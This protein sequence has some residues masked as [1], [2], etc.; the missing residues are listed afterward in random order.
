[1]IRFFIGFMMFCV[2]C[3]ALQADDLDARIYFQSEV[4]AA[5]VI[6]AESLFE[7]MKDNDE[8]RIKAQL[9]DFQ[10]QYSYLVD[11]LVTR[12]ALLWPGKCSCFATLKRL[13]V[14]LKPIQ[15]ESGKLY[16]GDP[17]LTRVI[18][19]IPAD[20]DEAGD[21]QPLVL[22]ELLKNDES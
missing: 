5:R 18:A 10:G 8:D 14:N 2:G 4:L 11:E 7:A 16:F 3:Q 13:G 6:Q 19:R 20:A 17:L 15:N 1:M 9:K 12:L 22:R 21:F